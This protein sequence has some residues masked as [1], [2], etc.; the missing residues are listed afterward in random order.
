MPLDNSLMNDPRFWAGHLCSSFGQIGDPFE[1]AKVV[2]AFGIASEKALLNWWHGATRY[3]ADTFDETDGILED[4]T[5]VE[6]PL[7]RGVLLQVLIHPGLAEY[8]LSSPG[9]EPL[10]LGEA[11]PHWRLPLL[12]YEEWMSLADSPHAQGL[13]LPGAWVTQGVDLETMRRSVEA[14]FSKLGARDLQ[15]AR[16]LSKDWCQ[17]MTH[18]S[19]HKWW[20]E[21]PLGWVTDC[22]HSTRAAASKDKALVQRLNALLAVPGGSPGA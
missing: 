1:P 6:V 2:S 15:A 3:D 12:R 5:R 4:P 13:L 17:T 19:E 14:L 20:H 7:P 21:E 10:L 9:S 22:E 18:A 8:K 16:S 11:G